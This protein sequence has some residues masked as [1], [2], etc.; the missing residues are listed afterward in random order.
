LNKVSIKWILVNDGSTQNMSN[1]FI[2][3]ISKDLSHFQYI[4]LLSN[5]GKGYATRKGMQQVDA[6]GYIYTDID[7]PYQNDDIVR[8]LKALQDGADLVIAKR[9]EQYYSKVSASRT[10]ISKRFKGLIRLLFNIPTTDTQAGLKGLSPKAKNL[11]L[12]TKVDRYLF[13]LELVKLCAKKNLK[14]VE[15]QVQLKEGVVLSKVSYKVLFTEFFNLLR[16]FFR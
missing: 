7:F 8:M 1:D 5:K 3:R 16:I 13:D 2:D 4:N 6:D 12:Q 15:L 10:W 14:I 9:S 11:L